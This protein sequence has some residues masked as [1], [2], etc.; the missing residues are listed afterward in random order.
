M[1]WND[2]DKL[3]IDFEGFCVALRYMLAPF[4]T[5]FLRTCGCR[6]LHAFSAFLPRCIPV[7]GRVWLVLDLRTILSSAQTLQTSVKGVN[8]VLIRALTGLCGSFRFFLFVV[9]WK[10]LHC[11]ALLIGRMETR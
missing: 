2:C 5:F 6:L 4:Y 3:S 8:R 9:L 7:S 10:L 11:D 1:A